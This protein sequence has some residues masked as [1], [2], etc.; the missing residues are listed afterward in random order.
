MTLLDTVT[1]GRS[2]AETR[3][4]FV[5]AHPDDE[6][7]VTGTLMAM[8][9]AHGMKVSVLTATR[10]EKGEVVPGSVPAGTAKTLTELRV[11]ELARGLDAFGVT[12]HFFLGEGYARASGQPARQYEDSGMVWVSPELAGP[13]PDAGPASLSRSDLDEEVADLVALITATKPTILI[14]YDEGGTYG[15]PD[16]VRVWEITA[17]AAARTN[18]PFIEAHPLAL[19][20]FEYTDLSEYRDTVVAAAQ[21][22]PTQLALS[23]DKLVLSGGQERSLAS[24]IAVRIHEPRG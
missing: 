18:L 20:G 23:G 14:S 16:H 2:A 6:T 15:H 7:L 4:L 24:G 10:G 9:V 13:A 22:F 21:C 11:A 19:D 3:P 12:D 1:G 17:A 5:H 8:C